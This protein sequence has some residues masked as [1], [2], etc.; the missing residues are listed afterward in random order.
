MQKEWTQILTGARR[1]EISDNKFPHLLEFLLQ[2]KERIE[3][4]VSQIRSRQPPE[5]KGNHIKTKEPKEQPKLREMDQCWM[6]HRSDAYHPIWKCRL[7]QSKS[8]DERAELVRTNN[9]CFAC[10]QVGHTNV[11][12]PR[13]FKCNKDGCDLP[14]HQ[15]LH[16]A[17]PETMVFHS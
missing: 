16:D 14:H 15:L 2:Y 8:P 10:L 4:N 7:F 12:C 9:A 11:D 13:N 3:Y 6:T 17:R 1:T 5:H